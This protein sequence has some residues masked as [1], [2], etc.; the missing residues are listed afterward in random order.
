MTRTDTGQEPNAE[1]RSAGSGGARGPVGRALAKVH[2][3]AA[4]ISAEIIQSGTSFLLSLVAVREL[5]AGDLGVFVL[6]YNCVV[7]SC[8]VT[9]GLIGDSLTVLD[10]TRRDVRGGLQV[11]SIGVAVSGGLLA[12][13]ITG[14]TGLLEWNLTPLMGLATAIFV[15]EDLVRRMLMAAMRF[16][17]VVAVDAT[18]FTVTLL[19]LLGF[20]LVDGELLMRDL[21]SSLVVAQIVGMFVGIVL[22]PRTERWWA[23]MRRSRWHDVLRYGGWR[24]AQQ[25]VRPAVMAAARVIII[26]AVGETLFGQLEAA[27]VYA[28]ASLIVNGAGGFLFASYAA[29]RKDSLRELI[30]LADRATVMLVGLSFGLGVVS[31]VLLPWLGP[32]I[33]NDKFDLNPVAVFGWSVYAAAT[34]VIMPYGSLAAVRGRQAAVMGTRVIE[35]VVSLASLALVLLAVGVD[36]WWAPYAMAV[37]SAAMG[38][39]IRQMILVPGAVEEERGPRGR[40]L[41]RRVTVAGAPATAVASAGAT[42]AAA[43]TVGPASSPAPPTQAGTPPP[44]PASGRWEPGVYD[45][46]LS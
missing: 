27:R 20:R 9:T 3:A 5:G 34:A 14:A 37:G 31:L 24:A 16:W 40:R 46:P 33:T 35:A 19:W 10:R 1:A 38:I 23:S 18:S 2:K 39:A 29:R 6:L 25:A 12:V 15:L 8:A 42:P 41:G 13:L 17:Y 30:P 28:P 7:L 22:L 4:S 32:I 26:V 44:D 36:V 21:L 43:P 11:V 45:E